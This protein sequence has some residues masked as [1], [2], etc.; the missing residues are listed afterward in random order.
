MLAQSNYLEFI[1]KRRQYGQSKKNTSYS[2]NPWMHLSSNRKQ[3]RKLPG[4]LS[5]EDKIYDP[6]SLDFLRAL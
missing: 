4:A 2:T 5:D 1:L 3:N 6:P